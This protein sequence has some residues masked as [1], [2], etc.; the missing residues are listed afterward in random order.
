MNP[1]PKFSSASLFFSALVA[2]G[3][4]TDSSAA[5][6]VYDARLNTLPQA[7]GFTLSEAGPASPPPS[8]SDS[9]FHQGPT[10]LA[11]EQFYH[12]NDVPLN[13]TNGFTLEATLKVIS[14]TY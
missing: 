13:L 11:G 1:R 14:S 12:R 3:S 7:Q 6:A 5:I 8:V 2:L 9:V 4:I 10:S